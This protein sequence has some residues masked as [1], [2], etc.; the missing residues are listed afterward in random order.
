MDKCIEIFPTILGWF[1]TENSVMCTN[2]F[3]E[4]ISLLLHAI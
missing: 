1:L 4:R 3:T 2:K